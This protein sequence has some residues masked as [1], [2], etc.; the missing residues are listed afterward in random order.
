MTAA[1]SPFSV[2]FPRKLGNQRVMS[3]T[4]LFCGKRHHQCSFWF[5]QSYANLPIC[6]AGRR[7]RPGIFALEA[8]ATSSSRNSAFYRGGHPSGGLSVDFN[9]K[10]QIMEKCALCSWHSCPAP[11]IC[12]AS[13]YNAFKLKISQSGKRGAQLTATERITPQMQG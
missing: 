5:I 2:C 8:A 11:E 12:L 10:V 3:K 6:R 9:P 1:Q 4:A 13:N 7:L